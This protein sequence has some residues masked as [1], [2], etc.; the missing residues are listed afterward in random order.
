M[1]W[2]KISFRKGAVARPDAL[3]RAFIPP[4]VAVLLATGWGV[5]AQRDGA[6]PAAEAVRP[7]VA[8]ERTGGARADRGSREEPAAPDQVAAPAFD[9][10][11]VDRP[12][13]FRNDF[14]APRFAGGYH[15]HAGIDIVAPK[16]TPV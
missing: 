12:R 1:F 13:W 2:G 8:V 9:R 10:C 4:M 7:P 6:A 14:G 3:T 16:G 5:S 15:A 11:P